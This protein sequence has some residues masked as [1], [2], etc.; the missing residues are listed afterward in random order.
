MTG[1]RATAAD[2]VSAADS[3]P[4]TDLNACMLFQNPHPAHRTFGDALGAEYVHFETGEGLADGSRTLD[5]EFARLETGTTLSGD[6]DVVIAEGTAPLQTLLAYGASHPSTLFGSTALVYLAA[7]ETF[8]TLRNRGTRHVWTALEPVTGRL[9]DG[10]IGVSETAL[11]WAR[12]YLGAVHTRV[13][14][15]PIAPAKYDR[16]RSLEPASPDDPVELLTA[17][18][19]KPANNVAALASAADRLPGVELTILGAGHDEEPYAS[20]ESVRTPGFVDLEAFAAAFARAS[21]YVQPSIGDAFPVAAMEGM[22][23][24]TPVIASTETGTREVLPE[25]NVFEPHVDDIAD[26]IDR[27]RT[28]DRTA[29][30]EMGRRHRQRIEDCTESRQ[31]A[32]FRAAVEGMVR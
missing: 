4:E 24:G 22:L 8:L 21:L 2:A 20:L 14:R 15:P 26:C 16:L 23:S 29:R 3:G 25:R 31:A 18:T 30:I 12:P 9:L 1:Q 13:V 17:G 27:V 19:T 6:Y 11:E 32:A 7:D 28:M 10:A 5:D